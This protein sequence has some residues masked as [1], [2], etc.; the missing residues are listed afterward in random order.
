MLWVQNTSKRRTTM[1]MSSKA[2]H[3]LIVLADQA[4]CHDYLEGHVCATAKAATCYL[5]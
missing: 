5:G 1:L 3:A 2:C 4:T